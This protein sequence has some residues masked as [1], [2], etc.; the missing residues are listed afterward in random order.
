MLIRRFVAPLSVLLVV[1][2]VVVRAQER[3]DHDVMW[4]IR[5]EGTNNSRILQTLHMFTDVYS[6]RLTG[7]PNLKAAGE[8]A[9]EQMQAWGLKNGRLEPW[10]FG[11]PGWTNE[12]L[13]AHIVEPV[14]DALVVEALSWTPGTSGPV[15]GP[16]V[17]ITLPQPAPTREALTAV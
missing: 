15:R 6:P 2:V 14:K 12:R 11:R 5:Q 3:V 16:A 10:D 17:R 7:S 8:W 4:K 9:V 1:G 13:S